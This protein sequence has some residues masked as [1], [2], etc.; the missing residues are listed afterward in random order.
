MSIEVNHAKVFKTALLSPDGLMYFHKCFVMI[1]DDDDPRRCHVD[2]KQDDVTNCFAF[3]AVLEFRRNVGTTTESF[4][5]TPSLVSPWPTS[6]PTSSKSLAGL[7]R[8]NF[9][10]ETYSA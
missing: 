1:V 4:V 9:C 3:K 6:S 2:S 10:Y 5:S 7:Y 8:L